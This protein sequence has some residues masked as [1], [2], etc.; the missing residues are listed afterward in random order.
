MWRKILSIK[1]KSDVANVD[2]YFK[3]KRS[4]KESPPP[5]KTATRSFDSEKYLYKN[6]GP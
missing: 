3:C 4:A 5:P 2:A 6:S 1:K